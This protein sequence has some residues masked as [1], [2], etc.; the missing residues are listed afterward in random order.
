MDE[1]L[2]H[3]P[4]P[5]DCTR[6]FRL[7][8]TPCIGYASSYWG[9]SLW[10]KE[11]GRP[12]QQPKARSQQGRSVMLASRLNGS[13]DVRRESRP[14]EWAGLASGSSLLSDLF[15][16]DTLGKQRRAQASAHR[17][18]AIARH[19][20]GYWLNLRNAWRMTLPVVVM[21]RASTNSI[22]RGYSC[23]A[24]RRLMCS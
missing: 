12:R 23:A 14:H 17:G 3:R 21:G 24:T 4:L 5:V 15:R 18:L 2:C 8:N 19:P 9:V 13:P 1:R 11:R 16:A 10:G 22:K 6:A 7:S 20:C